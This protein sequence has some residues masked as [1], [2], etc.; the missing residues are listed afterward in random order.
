MRLLWPPAL[1]EKHSP[2]AARLY[3]R[4]EK[5]IPFIPEKNIIEKGVSKSWHAAV[6]ENIFASR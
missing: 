2:S 3:S 1:G 4:E 5:G 6:S